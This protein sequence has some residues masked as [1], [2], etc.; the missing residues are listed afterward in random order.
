MTPVRLNLGQGPQHESP[1]VGAG[2]RKKR[3]VRPSPN[4][5]PIGDQIKIERAR[6]IEVTALAPE[7]GFDSVQGC[8]KRYRRER[9]PNR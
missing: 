9:G 8:K 5:I 2:M 6:G 7:I 3:R 1:R 4:N